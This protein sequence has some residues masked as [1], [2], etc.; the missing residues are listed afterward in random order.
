VS[1]EASRD[2]S[3]LSGGGSFGSLGSALASLFLLF[4]IELF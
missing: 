3:S 4:L 1:L 2:E